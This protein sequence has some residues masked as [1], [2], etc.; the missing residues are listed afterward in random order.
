MKI[1]TAFKKVFLAVAPHLKVDT[2]SIRFEFRGN[3][4]T[5][6]Q[7]PSDVGMCDGDEIDCLYQK[8]KKGTITQFGKS[9]PV[10]KMVR[11]TV[12]LHKLFKRNLSRGLQCFELPVDE[13]LSAL[14]E[15]SAQLSG[16][17]QTMIYCTYNNCSNSH[18]SLT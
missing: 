9:I 16:S 18:L 13:F 12:L 2:D 11:S 4:V 7:T 14:S 5:C 10:E 8:F 6:E 15:D 1:D 17:Q 3:A